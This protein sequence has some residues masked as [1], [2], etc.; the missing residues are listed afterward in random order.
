MGFGGLGSPR[1]LSAF[2]LFVM[3][4]L[5]ESLADEPEICARI[6]ALGELYTNKCVSDTVAARSLPPLPDV[7]PLSPQT[8]APADVLAGR[9]RLRHARFSR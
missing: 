1:F 2:L 7:F 9:A 6:F 5:V 3:D 4:A 8:M